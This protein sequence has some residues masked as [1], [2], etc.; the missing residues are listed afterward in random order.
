MNTLNNKTKKC[1]QPTDINY[2]QDKSSG[3]HQ[4]AIL[5]IDKKTCIKKISQLNNENKFYNKHNELIKNG[6]TIL[7]NYI[8]KYN[9]ICILNDIKYIQF[10][11][12]KGLFNQPLSIDIKIGY[13]SAS[14]KIIKNKTKKIYKIYSKLIKHYILDKFMSQSSNVGF[15]I[16]GVSLPNNI[17]L[18]KFD[19][20]KSNINKILDYYFTN[21]KNNKNL[22]LFIKI[23]NEFSYN[24][25]DS[26]FDKYRF[27]GA[28]IL[29]TY[30][31]LNENIN[32]SFKLI[33][34]ENSLILNNE[35]DIKNN[36][37]H[38]NKF[39]KSIKSLITILTNYLNNKNLL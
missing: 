17:K 26:N 7:K 38:A 35:N 33:D 23:L 18:S 28:S 24:I 1:K 25:E 36:A 14:K 37:K 30:D 2:C 27:V 21:D 11:N 12:L 20:M 19:V 9:G 22:N 16:E 29:F 5:S 34:F 8:P 10:E 39:R 6:I 13:K 4:G 3:G 32:P 31:G 15:R